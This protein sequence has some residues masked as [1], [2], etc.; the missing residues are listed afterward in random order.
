MTF[1][2]NVTRSMLLLALRQQ[3]EA[4]WTLIDDPSDEVRRE[5]RAQFRDAVRRY[6]EVAG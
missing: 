6:E 1:G 2:E 5:A 4:A 3:I